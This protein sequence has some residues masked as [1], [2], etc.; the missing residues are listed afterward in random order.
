MV[1]S[2]GVVL[3]WCSCRSSCSPHRSA[4]RCTD[5][6]TMPVPGTVAPTKR[7]CACPSRGPLLPGSPTS[8]PRHR[9]RPCSRMRGARD[10]GA[11]GAATAGGVQTHV[12]NVSF[13][14]VVPDDHHGHDHR[15]D[16]PGAGPVSVRLPPSRVTAVCLEAPPPAHAASRTGV[17]VRVAGRHLC[18]SH[19][20]VRDGRDRDRPR[21]RGVGPVHG[22]RPR[23]P[24]PR[25]G[26]RSVAGHVL[27]AGETGCRGDRGSSHLVSAGPGSVA[28]PFVA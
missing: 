21:H 24:Q 10:G 14:Q 5:R 9:N 27:P 25:E 20:G 16:G 7:L 12:V 19:P 13:R 23:G 17:V 15:P 1:H 11:D 22:R 2:W 3:L 26:H 18:Q 4:R 28:A 6:G 8:S